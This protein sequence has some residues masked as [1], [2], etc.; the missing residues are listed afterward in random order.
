MERMFLS[1][2]EQVMIEAKKINIIDVC[3]NYE[4]YAFMCNFY[5]GFMG[6]VLIDKLLRTCPGIENIYL[7][8]RKKKGKDIHTRIDE[9][10]DDPVNNFL[11][12]SFKYFS[13]STYVT[14]TFLST[15]TSFLA[16]STLHH[17]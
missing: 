6:K 5:L 1:Q 10:F 2:A 17:I 9:L 13:M 11:T 4:F 3:I 7:L 14:Q 12:P 8:I 15:L 16:S